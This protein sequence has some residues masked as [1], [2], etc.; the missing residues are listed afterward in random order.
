MRTQEFCMT[1]HSVEGVL[2]Y[3]VRQDSTWIHLDPR[4][5]GYD[6]YSIIENGMMDYIAHFIRQM[7]K[8]MQPRV[9]NIH[10]YIDL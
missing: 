10:V 7:V 8:L 5:L 6:I 2:E 9:E 4:R 1:K 3:D